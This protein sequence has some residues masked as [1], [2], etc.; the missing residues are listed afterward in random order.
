MNLIS[1]GIVATTEV[2]ERF[3][4]RAERRGEPTDWP[5][6][7]ATIIAEFGTPGVGMVCEPERVGQL[8]AF[9]ASD[10]G[11]YINAANLRIDGGIADT[12]TP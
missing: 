10:A 7:Q 12:V 5:S 6:I 8:V 11:A 3:V 4:A 1:P 2:R 9:V